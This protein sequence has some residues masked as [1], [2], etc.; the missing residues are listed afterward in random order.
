MT[1]LPREEV[2]KSLYGRLKQGIYPFKAPMG[3]INT[4]G[5]KVK[6]VDPSIAPFIKDSFR[7]VAEEEYSINII[8]KHL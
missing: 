8:R 4:G 2:I 3:Y 6:E 5:G 7:L 1:T